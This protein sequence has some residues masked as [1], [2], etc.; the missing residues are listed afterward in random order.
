MYP[1]DT[2]MRAA[3]FKFDGTFIAVPLPEYVN[4]AVVKL[5]VTGRSR[6]AIGPD[7]FCQRDRMCGD[8]ESAF[9]DITDR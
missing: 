2:A 4:C 7:R 5:F 6:K 9:E 8:P 3:R 1:G